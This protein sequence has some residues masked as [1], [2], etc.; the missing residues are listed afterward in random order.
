MDKVYK[1]PMLLGV[2]NLISNICR[3]PMVF[4]R[5][6]IKLN[7]VE[8]S[9]IP[10]S[11][12]G[13]Y[14]ILMLKGILDYGSV[15][16]VAETSRL[17]RIMSDK[18]RK[19]TISSVLNFNKKYKAREVDAFFK[20]DGPCEILFVDQQCKPDNEVVM[21]KILRKIIRIEPSKHKD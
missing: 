13:D 21:M 11:N 17:G 6:K 10:Y 4:H 15:S 1:L 3:I 12:T 2:S 9:E 7:I 14:I 16:T 8:E 20:N 18:G 5:E 19:T